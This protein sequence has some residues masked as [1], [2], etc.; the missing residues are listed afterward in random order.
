LPDRS[1]QNGRSCFL[2]DFEGKTGKPVAVEGSYTHIF[3]CSKE[4]GNTASGLQSGR[5]HQNAVTRIGGEIL[6]QQLAFLQ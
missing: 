1:L 5:N 2:F 6:F 3:Y 4:F